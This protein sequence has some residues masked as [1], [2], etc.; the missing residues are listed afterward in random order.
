MVRRHTG[1]LFDPSSS[2]AGRQARGRVTQP[3][4]RPPPTT[5]LSMSTLRDNL[6]DLV[7]NLS[8]KNYDE[9]FAQY[10][11]WFDIGRAHGHITPKDQVYNDTRRI[12]GPDPSEELIH[13]TAHLLIRFIGDLEADQ[14]T[15][16]HAVGL[17]EQHSASALHSFFEEN[18][19]HAKFKYLGKRDFLTRVNLIAYWANLGHVEEETIRNYILQSLTSHPVLYHHQAEALFIL[20]KLAGATFGAYADPSVIDN[21]FEL[22][23]GHSHPDWVYGNL[24]Q[25]RAPRLV[26]GGHRVNMDFQVVSLRERGWEGLPPPPVFAT[27]KSKPAGA[28]QKDSTAATTAATPAITS[29]GLPSENLEPQPVPQPPPFLLE[30][31]ITPEIGTIHASPVIQSPSLSIV[32]LSDFAADTSDDESLIDSTAITSHAAFYLEDGNVEVLCGNTLFRVHVSVLSP[33]SH[34]LGQMLSKVNLAAAESPNGCP[35][36]LSSDVAT[37]FV[38]LLKIVYLPAYATAP[39]PIVGGLFR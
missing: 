34:V 5:T 9:S 17:H 37:D 36:I 19:L 39:A 13:P 15:S 24:L 20:F 25:V 12:V 6:R 21:C 31:D 3:P 10:R 14:K 27:G 30:S 35:R 11:F 29:L 7:E 22:L 23:K 28:D 32:A 26:K 1:P 16:N 8:E 4:P 2:G 33:Y 38:T 18:L